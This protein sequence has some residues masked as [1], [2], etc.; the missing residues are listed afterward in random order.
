MDL[1]A[2]RDNIPSGT[3]RL[4]TRIARRLRLPLIAAPMFTLSGPNLVIAACRSG[5]IGA[6]PTA[7]ARTPDELDAWLDYI[8]KQ[9]K[10]ADNQLAP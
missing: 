5:V 9:L 1:S 4:P 2:R 6:F 8:C 3:S 10:R 7:N